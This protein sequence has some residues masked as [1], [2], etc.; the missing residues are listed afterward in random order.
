LKVCKSTRTVKGCGVEKPL[1]GF[2]K[3]KH[4]HQAVCKCCIS[5]HRRRHDREIKIDP[6]AELFNMANIAWR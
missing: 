4:G 5:D 6:E 1:S 3:T 2:P